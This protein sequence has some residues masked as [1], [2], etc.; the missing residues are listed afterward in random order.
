LDEKGVLEKVYHRYLANN[1]RIYMD[2]LLRFAALYQYEIRFEPSQEAD[3]EKIESLTKQ[4]LLE[5]DLETEYYAFYHS[6]FAKLLLKSYASRPSFQRRYRNI[7]QFTIQQIK[8]YLLSFEDYPDN[9]SEV[10]FNTVTNNG[11]DIFKAL[12]EDEQIKNLALCF[13]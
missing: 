5:I 8:T 2:L 1:P 10:F 6:D 3:F 12:L 4:G 9:L 13:Y 11:I 7:Q